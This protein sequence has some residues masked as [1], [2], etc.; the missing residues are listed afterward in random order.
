MATNSLPPL[1]A[2]KL[3]DLIWQAPLVPV[4]LAF[5]SGIILDR[6]ASIRLPTSLA[7]VVAFV[8]A[9]VAS[10]RKGQTHAPVWLWLALAAAG[11]SWHQWYRD[12]MAPNDIRLFAT[13]E[14]RPVRLRGI[15]DSEPVQ[16]RDLAADPL[17]SFATKPATRLTVRVRQ[18]EHRSDWH[19]VSGLV[20]STIAGKQMPLHVGD[21]IELTGLLALPPAPGNPGAF[22]YAEFLRD[23]GIG[24]TLHVPDASDAVDVLREGWPHSAWGWL[25]VLRARGV[26]LLEEHLP[27]GQRGVAAALLLGD[28]S[29]MT[30]DEWEQYLRTGVVHV[31]AISGQHLV[32]LAAFLWFACRVLHVRRRT[33]ALVIVLLLL[34]YALLTGGRPP[35]MRAAWMVTA[36][37]GGMI[38]RRPVLPANTFALA[39]LGVAAFNPTDIFN[40]GCQLS[41][42]AV[43]VLI[44]GTGRWEAR[45]QDPL[46]KLIDESRSW[47]TI[48]AIRF[49]RW[50]G[51]LYAVNAIVWLAVTPLIAARYHVVSP[52]ALLIGP[53]MVLFSSLA[54]LLGFGLLLT[55]P[56]LPPLAALFTVLTKASLYLADVLVRWSSGWPGAYSFVPDVPAWWLVVFY[57]GL[58]ACLSVPW[59]QGHWRRSLPLGVG[60]LALG[61]FLVYWPPDHRDFRCTFLA[62]G[63]GGCTVIETPQNRVILY[64]AGAITGPDVTRRHIAPFLWKRGYRRIDEI[65]VSH[66][67]LDHFNGVPQLLE[68]FAVGRVTLTPSFAAHATPGI[69][70][71]LRALERMGLP[72]RVV[73][74]P[75]EWDVD[76][77]HFEVLHPPAHGPAGVENVRSLVLMVRHEGLTALLT[78]DLQ[79]PGLKRV[80]ALPSRPVDVLMAPHHGSR[81]SNTKEL[82]AWARPKFVVSCQG[83]PTSVPKEPNPYE[84]LGSRWLSTWSQGAVTI[85]RDGNA[86][87][88]ETFATR[89]QWEVGADRS[90]LP[91]REGR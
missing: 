44:W 61:G 75:A 82:A 52:V 39:W 10:K 38:L 24:A 21:E 78:G 37:A 36:Y 58:L 85:R 25:A 88:V 65:I 13:A 53:P 6:I 66:G 73:H 32:V 23:Q 35:V 91:F 31:L 28:G 90:G 45:E 86:W 16:V 55:A 84:A 51:W 26:T 59:L 54:L 29:A 77:V 42:V 43:A 30:H 71:T 14:G 2:P 27:A 67:D 76:G 20:Q 7:C 49:F 80:L 19:P 72:S 18:L 70:Y 34:G 17:R 15:V 33:A 60:W 12:S 9:F 40:T 3:R 68:R 64:D 89:N 1:A 87:M 50:L 79:E 56:V 47:A 69:S 48:V 81:A 74:A 5:T 41:F 46:E 83:P 4:A 22:D 57:A 63:H 62:V 11:A 8:A